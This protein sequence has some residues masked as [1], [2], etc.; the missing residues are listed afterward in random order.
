MELRI[1]T[2]VGRL[3]PTPSGHLHLGNALAFAA[4]WLSARQRGGQVLLR[5]EDVDRGRAR[6]AVAESQRR[7]LRWLGCDWD[8]E[9][10]CQSARDYAPWL[11]LLDGRTYTCRCSRKQLKASGGHCDCAERDL[12][13][14]AIRFRLSRMPLTFV[15]RRHGRVLTGPDDHPDPVLRRADGEF[16]YTLAVV[17]DDIADGVTEVVRGGD[18]LHYTAVQIQLWRAFGATPP[19]YLHTPVVIG[20]DGRKLSKTHGDIELQSLRSAGWT[21]NR[22]W[23][24]VLPWLGIPHVEHLSDAVSDFDA[25]GGDRDKVRFLSASE[26]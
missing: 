26:T 7:D 24:V 2:P 25:Q 6:E 13:Q 1:L 21:P 8:L 22:V 14:G 10:P 3:A 12:E 9:T 23:Q 20:G 16:T 4:C 17:A 5:M 19:T 18:L 11:A 15:D